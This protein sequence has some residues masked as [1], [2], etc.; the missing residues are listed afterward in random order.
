MKSNR[1]IACAI[2]VL[3]SGQAFSQVAR[4]IEVTASASP[5]T[6]AAGEIR[7][8]AVFS[9]SGKPLPGLKLTSSVGMTNMDMGTAHPP[10]KEISPGHYVVRPMLLM[11]GPWRIELTSANPKFSVNF[12]MTAG[13]KQPWQP[14]KQAINIVGATP[15]PKEDSPKQEPARPKPVDPPVQ[16]SQP[17]QQAKPTYGGHE[18]AGHVMASMPLLK[19]KTT[20]TVKGDE[21]WEVRTGF[22]RLEP[23]VR[24]MILMMVGGSGMEGMKMAPMKMIFDDANFTESSETPMQ[25]MPNMPGKSSESMQVEAKLER[26]K[27]G[28][29]SVVIT[30]T[31]PGGKPIEK[32]KLLASV[33]MTNMDMGTTHPAVKALGRGKYALKANFSMAGPWR[34]SLSVQTGSSSTSY[35]FD[36]E[37]K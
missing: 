12:E 13:A 30:I 26:P 1:H 18:M 32:A 34:I 7:L 8:E 31:G 9:E 3:L 35:S 5:K 27:V 16:P 33:G 2:A 17:A 15:A 6:V 28:D 29:N 4:T 23:M 19:E 36:F 21:D 25:N 24:M 11:N 22:G 10:V 14:A 20:Y 37:A